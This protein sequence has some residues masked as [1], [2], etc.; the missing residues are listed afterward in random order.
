MVDNGAAS[1]HLLRGSPSLGNYNYLVMKKEKK[2]RELTPKEQMFVKEFLVDLNGAQAAIRA[3]YA[4]KSARIT[5]SKLLTKTNIQKAL[6]LAMDKRARK[7]ELN[8]EYVLNGL[9]EVAERCMQHKPVMYFDYEDKELKQ[10]TEIVEKL[11]GTTSEEGVYQFDSRGANTALSKLGE[12]FGLFKKIY[13]G[14]PDNPLFP[15]IT[16]KRA[17]KSD[18]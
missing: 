8:A 15:G 4:P 10:E 3:G 5:A 7:V 9:V 6:R 14:D 13:G 17:D 12:H 2:E 18:K 11:D 16:I 1:S